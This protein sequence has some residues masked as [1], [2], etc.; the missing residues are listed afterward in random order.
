MRQRSIKGEFV[1]IV[2]GGSFASTETI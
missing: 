2:E 1:V